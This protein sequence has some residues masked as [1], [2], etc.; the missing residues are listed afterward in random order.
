MPRVRALI[1]SLLGLSSDSPPVQS[2]AVVGLDSAAAS[3]LPI[4]AMRTVTVD[5]FR[6]ELDLTSQ[7][8]AIHAPPG[9]KVSFGRGVEPAPSEATLS[10]TL[11]TIDPTGPVSASV[12]AQKAKIFDDGLCDACG[13]RSEIMR[14]I[15][16]PMG[17]A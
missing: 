10:A 15:G 17:T 6:V 5:G 2:H 12:L 13:T 3:G 4:S 7:V 9:D 8:L 11:G 16:V 1:R 14:R